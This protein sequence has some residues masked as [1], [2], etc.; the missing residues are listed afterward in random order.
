MKTVAVLSYQAVF[1]LTAS[2]TNQHSISQL[3]SL[4]TYTV[5]CSTKYK[6]VNLRANCNVCFELLAE[7]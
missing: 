1:I 6:A 3:A 5:C 7:A 2:E 4:L